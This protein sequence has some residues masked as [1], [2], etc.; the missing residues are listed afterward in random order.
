[1]VEW[2]SLPTPLMKVDAKEALMSIW[3]PP[4]EAAVGV[5][6]AA[7]FVTGAQAGHPNCGMLVGSF[8]KAGRAT[9]MLLLAE[10]Q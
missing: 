10:L 6:A 9:N 4:C 5:L 7:Q 2:Q 3:L 8:S 1:M